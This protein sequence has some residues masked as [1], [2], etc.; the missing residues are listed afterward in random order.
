MTNQ[1]SSRRQGQGDSLRIFGII[2][3]QVYTVEN[4]SAQGDYN[5]DKYFVHLLCK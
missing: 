5:T 4:N 1:Y 3:G 2:E